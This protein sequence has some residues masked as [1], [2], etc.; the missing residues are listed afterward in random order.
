MDGR[1]DRTTRQQAKKRSATMQR[2]LNGGRST[3]PRLTFAARGRDRAIQPSVGLYRRRACGT[4]GRLVT[5]ELVLGGRPVRHRR[6]KSGSDPAGRA[7]RSCAG[8]PELANQTDRCRAGRIQPARPE[9]PPQSREYLC[10]ADRGTGDCSIWSR[11]FP[12]N[13]PLM[14]GRNVEGR[15]YRAFCRNPIR[16]SSRS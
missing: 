13:E 6:S 10:S 1:F 15:G 8:V 11:G 7:C 12:T 16:M 9:P 3:P 5:A 4:P 2:G 14:C